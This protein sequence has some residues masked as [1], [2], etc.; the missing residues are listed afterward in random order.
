[1][2]IES[3]IQTQAS[4]ASKLEMTRDPRAGWVSVVRLV[5]GLDADPVGHKPRKCT[6][7]ILGMPILQVPIVGGGL[8]KHPQDA[9]YT[10]VVEG[11]G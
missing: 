11:R 10:F 5:Y 3:L 7:L 9:E 1:M 6:C 4:F 2:F 8:P